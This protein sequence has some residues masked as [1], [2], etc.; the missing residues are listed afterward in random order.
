M[1]QMVIAAQD[2]WL[3]IGPD[4]FKAAAIDTA[5]VVLIALAVALTTAR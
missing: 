5:I 3:G 4:L 1:P 2:M